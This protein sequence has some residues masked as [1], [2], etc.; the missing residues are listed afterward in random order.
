MDEGRTPRRH[1]RLPPSE[2]A[3]AKALAAEYG[4]NPYITKGQR[5][6]V[7]LTLVASEILRRSREGD[8]TAPGDWLSIGQ[9]RLRRR[10]EIP[11]PS[12]AQLANGTYDA[13]LMVFPERPRGPLPDD[14]DV[15][16]KPRHAVA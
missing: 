2:V 14:D 4:I 3:G 7:V 9:L 6:E 5:P 12:M 10:R 13:R 16:K 15:D 1:V 8:R 11:V